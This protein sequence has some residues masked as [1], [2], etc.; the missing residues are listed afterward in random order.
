MY[1]VDDPSTISLFHAHYEA[2]AFL[3]K[4]AGRS[5][6]LGGQDA[7]GK[8]RDAMLCRCCVDIRT[9]RFLPSFVQFQYYHRSVSIR[10]ISISFLHHVHPYSWVLA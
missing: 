8:E 2:M 5:M 6:S 4:C 7:P 1:E 9:K 3:A 10:P